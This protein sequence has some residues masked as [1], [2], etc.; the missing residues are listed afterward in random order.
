PFVSRSFA[1][2]EKAHLQLR[3]EAFNIFNHGN[4]VSFFGNY[5]N[6]TSPA[7]GLGTNT[8]GLSSQLTP[9]E[10]QFSAGVSF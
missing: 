1:L 9:R 2:G 4:F 8:I 3:A 6:G 7:P 10:F 5:G